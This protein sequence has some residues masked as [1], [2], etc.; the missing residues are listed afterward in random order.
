M[1]HITYFQTKALAEKNMR[2]VL[3]QREQAEKHVRVH[4]KRTFSL[5]LQLFM[6]SM[7]MYFRGCLS[8]WILRLRDGQMER[9]EI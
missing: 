4:T 7:F 3:S 5:H 6:V 2:D 1:M 9:K 8:S